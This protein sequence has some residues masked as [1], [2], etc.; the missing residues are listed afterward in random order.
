[1]SEK[2]IPFAACRLKKT[3]TNF[4]WECLCPYCG[5]KHTHGGGSI[6]DDPMK[7]LGHRVSHCLDDEKSS[8]GYILKKF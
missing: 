1:M 3:K 5:K 2:L 7:M 4:L 8:A 6:E